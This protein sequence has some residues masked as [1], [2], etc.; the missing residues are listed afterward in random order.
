MSRKSVFIAVWL[1]VTLVGLR[2][3]SEFAMMT[4]HG[5]DPQMP[6]WLLLLAVK[7]AF[8]FGIGLLPWLLFASRNHWLSRTGV[9]VLVVWTVA[10]I[11]ATAAYLNAG[12]ALANSSNP[13][14]SPERLRALVDFTGIQAGYELD[15]RLASNPNTPPDALRTLHKRQQLGT[16]MCLA[17]NP[18]TPTDILEELVNHQD[19]W[20][21]A[22]LARNPALP[23]SVRTRITPNS[24]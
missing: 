23:P 17:S 22:S 24:D 6:I 7:L 14:T 13:A 5:S 11:A 16:E 18:N 20:V 10:I 8:W 3:A 1:I 15:N 2:A 4:A 21:R 12:R 19:K 9:V